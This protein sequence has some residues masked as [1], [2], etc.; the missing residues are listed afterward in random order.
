MD[1]ELIVDGINGAL[2]TLGLKETARVITVGDEY[3]EEVSVAE[4]LIPVDIGRRHFGNTVAIIQEDAKRINFSTI[5]QWLN[6]SHPHPHISDGNSC[7]SGEAM[8][9]IAEHIHHRNWIGAV[10][11]IIATI[12]NYNPSSPLNNTI[13]GLRVCNH[14]GEDMD[15]E[16]HCSK[17]NA[18]I[19]SNCQGKKC[20]L[21]GVVHCDDCSEDWPED[22]ICTSHKLYYCEICGENHDATSV[23]VETCASCGRKGCSQSAH[24][25]YCENG[26]GS[27]WCT[28]YNSVDG[29]I[30]KICA[31]CR[32]THEFKVYC[33]ECYAEKGYGG[34]DEGI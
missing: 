6:T 16:I 17:C 33:K 32:R 28:H 1:T 31:D 21:C 11:K 34:S 22:D 7:I 18:Y 26:P 15:V 8:D 24:D 9:E 19:C 12:G 2:R 5:H 30:V 14:C 20:S 4:V 10:A 23:G 29:E 3:D 25:Y 27:S 13:D